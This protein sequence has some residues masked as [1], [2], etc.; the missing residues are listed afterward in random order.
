VPIASRYRI[1]AVPGLGWL[2]DFWLTHKLHYLGAAVLLFLTAYVATA[3]RWSGAAPCAYGPG[4]DARR[5]NGLLIATGAVRVLKNLHGVN[6]S[7]QP[8]MLV[9]WAHLG[10][11]FLLGGLALWRKLS[12]GTYWAQARALVRPESRRGA[13]VS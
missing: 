3:G 2:G 7:P 6:F 12:G 11:A 13:P 8:V 1:V 9:D 10:L 5:H 4:L